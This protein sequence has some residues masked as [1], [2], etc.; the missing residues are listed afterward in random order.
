MSDLLSRV[1][2]IFFTTVTLIVLIHTKFSGFTLYT[3]PIGILGGIIFTLIATMA[4]LAS[5]EALIWILMRLPFVQKST[6]V[7]SKKGKCTH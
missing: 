5:Y 1:L 2:A 3:I 6:E 7:D 4:L